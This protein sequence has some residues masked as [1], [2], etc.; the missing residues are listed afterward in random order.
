MTVRNVRV[1]RFPRFVSLLALSMI[2]SCDDEASKGGGSAGSGGAGQAGSAGF[3]GAAAGASGG[4]AMAGLGGFA[5]GGAGNSGASA[6][7]GLAATG[8]SAAVAGVGAG[9]GGAAASSGSAGSSGVSGGGTAGSSA[10]GAGGGGGTTG[11][12][13][14][15][16]SSDG[17]CSNDYLLCEDFESTELGD[18]PEGWTRH[19]DESA[20]QEDEERGKALRL[21][22]I[23]V[24]ERRIYHDASMLGDAHWGRIYYRVEL[25]VPDAFVHSTLVAFGGEG[26]TRGTSEFRFIDTVKQAVDTPDVA[27]RHNF[28]FNVEPE[29]SGEFGRET[30]YDWFFDGEWHCAEYH[31]DASNQSYAFYLDG[32]QE[33]A[34]EDGAG[35]YS[36]TDIP[37]SFE[38]VRIGWINYQE[39]PPGFTAWIDDVAFDDQRIGCE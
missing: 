20:V 16:P 11:G 32:T 23:P 26:P 3:A 12:S 38:T 8:G 18:I 7:A 29:E 1:A 36:R 28:L 9:T 6:S 27:S 15:A 14:G 21:G 13:A 5:P 25:P 19:G 39:S 17:G 10:G 31:V 4:G 24:W 34:F 35:N 37:D 30:G 33:L 22:A 2:T